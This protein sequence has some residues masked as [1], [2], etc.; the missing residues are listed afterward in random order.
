[1]QMT[2]I[3]NLKQNNMNTSKAVETF[4]KV[5]GFAGS[6]LLTL[7]AGMFAFLSIA[8][9]IM[10]IVDK[11]FFSFVACLVAAF[12]AWITWSIRKVPLL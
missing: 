5:L 11:E 6:V 4:I 12:L 8:A 9:F 2:Q 7:L 1:M 10:S 3:I